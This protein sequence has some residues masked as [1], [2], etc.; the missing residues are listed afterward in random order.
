MTPCRERGRN[1]ILAGCSTTIAERHGYVIFRGYQ[2]AIWTCREMLR[3]SLT[4]LF[5]PWRTHTSTQT[6]S[7][8]VPSPVLHALLSFVNTWQNARTII[9]LVSRDS[10]YYNC[11]MILIII[12][13]N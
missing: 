2:I 12:F 1:E 3:D 5:A 4:E 13:T 9:P 8:L 10:D 7:Y 11:I 6:S